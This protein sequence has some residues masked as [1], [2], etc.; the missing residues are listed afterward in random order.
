M[1]F[2]MSVIFFP[3]KKSIWEFISVHIEE[4]NKL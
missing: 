1:G 3:E 2:C 4:E